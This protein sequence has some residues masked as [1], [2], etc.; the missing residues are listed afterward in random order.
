MGDDSTQEVTDLDSLDDLVAGIA[1]RPIDEHPGIY[2]EVDG[3][4]SGRLGDL[5]DLA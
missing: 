5:D 2:A 3:Q 4:L 1:D